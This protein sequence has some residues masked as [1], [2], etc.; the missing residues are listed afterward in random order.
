MARAVATDWRLPLLALKASNIFDKYVG[1]SEGKISRA[2]AIAE[3]IAPCVL[4]VDEIEKLGRIGQHGSN[5]SGVSARVGGSILTWMADKSLTNVFVVATAN[6]PERL[7]RLTSAAVASTSGSSSTCPA[8]VRARKS[9]VRTF[10]SAS[11]TS[12]RPLWGFPA[13][14]AESHGY[15][16]AEIEAVIVEAKNLARHHAGGVAGAVPD[17][18][19]AP[20]HA[21]HDP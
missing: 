7:T 9:S 14:V 8:C 17:G 1:E 16:G 6:N 5:D 15:T 2:L 11:R 10:A 20:S 3:A 21:F 18:A 19:L 12:M 4:W 13:L